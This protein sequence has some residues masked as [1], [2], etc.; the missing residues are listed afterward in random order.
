MKKQNTV[1]KAVSQH[2]SQTVPQIPNTE[3]LM[4]TVMAMS[5][6]IQESQNGQMDIDSMIDQVTTAVSG[7][8][9]QNQMDKA[10]Q[11]QLK[12]MTKNV[13][14]TLMT[15]E[16]QN[17]VQNSKVDIPGS[18]LVKNEDTSKGENNFKEPK[19]VKNY[20][21]LDDV[22]SVDALNP[23]TKDMV[24]NL[25]VSLQELFNGHEK[26]IAITR[27]RIKKDPK[28]NKDKLVEE[29]KKIVVPIEKGM[30]D[31][32]VIRY[33]K[34]SNELPGYDTGDIII[35]LRENG[36]EYFEREGDDLFISKNISL[37]ESYATATGLINLTVR[38]LDNSFLKLESG[39]VPL[40]LHDGLRKVEGQG[41]PFFRKEGR[42]DLY[43]RFNLVLPEKFESSLVTKLKPVFPPISEDIIYNDGTKNGFDTNGI[44]VIS[45]PLSRVTEEDLEKMKYEDYSDEYSS[46]SSRSSG[47][48]SRSRSRS[49]SG[50]SSSSRDSFD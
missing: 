2:V 42:G 32:Q 4:K 43:I 5:K 17:S 10:S 26:K 35:V 25:N 7:M 49:R 48:R 9:G 50:S 6:N 44:R 12:K 40:H 21:D 29:K 13:F 39:E 3:N 33:S 14:G 20:E 24:I 34:Q 47:S 37:Y 38:T 41:M 28:T 23:R 16:A 46:E 11:E 19:D 18:N 27:K 45:C 30:K 36:H 31:E 8:M 15:S 22:E 1:P